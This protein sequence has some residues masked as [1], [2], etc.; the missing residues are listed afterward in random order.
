MATI[1]EQIAALEAILNAG[2]TS[3]SVDGQ[4]VTY[5]LAQVRKRL[6]ELTRSN[7]PS[8]NP[9]VASIDL[10]SSQ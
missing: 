10:Q 4:T 3:A 9:T 8:K 1:E 2:V 6:K 7:D 5:D